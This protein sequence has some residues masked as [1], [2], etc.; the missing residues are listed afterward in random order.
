[1]S[2]LVQP[3]ASEPEET[4]YR[5]F[6]RFSEVI[7]D[8][9]DKS[10]WFWGSINDRIEGAQASKR[11]LDLE[12]AIQT[13]EDV[14]PIMQSV[15]Q[16]IAWCKAEEAFFERD[17][18][19]EPKDPDDVDNTR[20]ISRAEVKRQVLLLIDSFPTANVPNLRAFLKSMID[21]IYAESPNPI[22]LE[23]ACRKMRRTLKKVPT[24]AEVM[25]AIKATDKEWGDH[26]EILEPGRTNT[27]YFAAKLE[28]LR[29]WLRLA[30]KEE[31]VPTFKGGE[32]VRHPTRG[33]GVVDKGD[34]Y[35]EDYGV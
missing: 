4:D 16:K 11:Q 31:S 21:E 19:W 17:E 12:L 34:P 27:E 7:A 13:L 30:K 3:S 2:K 6:H 35:C 15:D 24:I 23:A 8:M 33:L 29:G 10:K 20:W 28:N 26:W 5:R 32:R 25:E 22:V 14:L 1:M 18:L 9:T